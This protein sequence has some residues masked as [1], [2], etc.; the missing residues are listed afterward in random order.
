M[1][2][3]MLMLM[4]SNLCYAQLSSTQMPLELER[5][6]RDMGQFNDE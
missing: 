6:S 5:L 2:M 3:P 4:L 1:L